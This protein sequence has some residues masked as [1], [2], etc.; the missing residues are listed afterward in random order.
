VRAA[1]AAEDWLHHHMPQASGTNATLRTGPNLDSSLGPR[2]EA[3]IEVR[4][5]EV[6]DEYAMVEAWVTESDLP[7]LP[8]LYR[9]TRFYQVTEQGW[10]RVNPPATFYQPLATLQA[11]RFTFVYGPRDASAVLA[12]AQQVEALDADLRG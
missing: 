6:R 12:V 10:L 5:V 9:E 7:W 1:V 2:A 4:H 8:I 3:R 11:G